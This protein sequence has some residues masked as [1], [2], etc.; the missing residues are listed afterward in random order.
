MFYT[1][2][3][4]RG[5]STPYYVGKG[6]GRRAFDSNSHNVKCPKDKHR[7]FVQY[8]ESEEKALET[9]KWWISFY[10]RKDNGTGI[11]RNLTDGGEN[12]P[13]GWGNTNTKGMK[14]SEETK[15]KISKGV[16]LV[17]HKLQG[18]LGK[19]RS[20]ESRRK[21]GNTLRGKPRTIELCRKVS[22]ALMGHTVSAETRDKLRAAA[23]EQ[24]KRKRNGDILS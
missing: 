16:L 5:D 13:V 19:T 2:L 6:K 23:T 15:K 17:R 11:L 12:P 4:L 22:A 21:Q 8:W 20:E 24:W 1:Y 18:N 7:I 3:W 9:E 14:H 10:G